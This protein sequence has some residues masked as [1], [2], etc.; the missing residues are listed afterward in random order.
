MGCPGVSAKPGSSGTPASA[1]V[2]LAR[3]LSPIASI[4][5][6][7]GPTKTSPAAAQARANAAFSARKP[8]PGWTMVAPDSRA[9][10][11]IASASR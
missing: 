10:P 2:R 11:T 4:A 1:T 3:I 8:Y 6:G 9:A 5:S 7:G